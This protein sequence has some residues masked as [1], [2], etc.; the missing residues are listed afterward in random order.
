MSAAS[1]F[2]MFYNLLVLS[3]ATA[4]TMIDEI[5]LKLGHHGLFHPSDIRYGLYTAT[6]Q[7]HKLVR[8]A[9]LGDLGAGP[10]NTFPSS[11]SPTW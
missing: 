6:S 4:E 11:I 5:L 10:P 8:G 1:T 9:T 2:I 7:F 3:V